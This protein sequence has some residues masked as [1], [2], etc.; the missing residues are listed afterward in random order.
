MNLM[1]IVTRTI[2]GIGGIAA[3]ATPLYA[4]SRP[5]VIIVLSDDQGYGDLSCHGNPLI[6]TP[7][8]DQL[9]N[10]SL[11][12]TDFHVCPMST[13]TRS[14]LLTGRDAV[15]NGASAVCQGRSMLR[16]DIPTV[17]D[18]FAAEGYK[19][20]HYGKWHLGDSYPYR[21]QDRGFQE[22]IHHG[23]F[24]I[25]SIADHYLNKDYWNGH[26]FDQ[27]DKE[28][29]TDGYCTDVW[30]DYAIDYL[31]K[32]SE[33]GKPFLMYLALNCA[34]APHLVDQKYAEPYM[35]AFKDVPQLAKF[36]GQIVNLDENLGRMMG[37]LKKNGLDD[38]TILLFMTDNGTCEKG[39]A[40]FYNAGMRGHKTEALEG[41]HRVP[42][43]FHWPAGGFNEHRE[44]DELTQVQDV[45]PTLLDFCKVP[46]AKNTTFSG[47]SL[48]PLMKGKVKKLTDR[49]LVVDYGPSREE[50]F[51]TVMWGK[52][53]L[54]DTGE[55]YNVKDDSRQDNNVASQYPEIVRKMQSHYDNWWKSVRPSFEKVR[56]IHIGNS[57]SLITPLYC[58]DWTGSYADNPNNLRRMRGR[59]GFWP[60]TVEKSGNYRIS[61]ARWWFDA[62]APIKGTYRKRFPFKDAELKDITQATISF[63][64]ETYGP[65]QVDVA[66]TAIVFEVTLKKG[67]NSLKANFLDA[68]GKVVCGAPFVRIEKL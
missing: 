48:A 35:E 6:K 66:D 38:N 44:I 39:A 47:V 29:V 61:I 15:E 43:F 65:V 52:W 1:S 26:Y 9:Y 13:P 21:P 4:E 34:H 62:Q 54:L 27:D 64:G 59:T 3:V 22:T 56:R 67:N 16:E 5:N 32:R 2:A 10:Q 36:F 31:N 12:F 14:E 40:E 19:T 20:V 7:F 50:H 58:N 28:V 24:G 53:R 17:A 33:D 55:L 68:E 11:C 18:M 49:M 41:G 37:V 60:L 63:E 45:L 25:Q 8:M 51:S 42:L 57:K 23:A 46:K 30:F